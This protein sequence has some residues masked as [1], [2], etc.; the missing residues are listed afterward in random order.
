MGGPD[1]L[2]DRERHVLQA[3]VD[4]HI[5]T[6]EPVGSRALAS[7]RDLGVSSATIRSVMGL[8]GERGLIHQPHTSAGRIPTDRG[9][10][11]YVDTLLRL[12][13]PSEEERK[14]IMSRIDGAGAIDLAIVEA[15]RVLSKLTHQACV[16]VAP[17]PNGVR[18][19][20][21]EFV[22][23]R[24]DAILVILV[25]VEGLV[26]NRLVEWRGAPDKAP[27]AA[28][29]DRMGNYLTTMMAGCTFEEGRDRLAREVES[30]RD[31]LSL[32]E[33]SALEVGRV[34][35]DI[36]PRSAAS[37]P[38]VHVEGKAHLLEASD[39]AGLDKMREIFHVLEER[40][41]V[42]ELFD[43]ASSA[44]GIRIFIGGE[45]QSREFS[46]LTVVT[47]PYGQKDGVLGTLGVIGPTRLDYARVVPLVD[48]TAQL[49]SRILS[50]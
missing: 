48:L 9:Y 35:L 6:A 13:L 19:K 22:R 32:L 8:L 23:L 12:Q 29:L 28:E 21:V 25:S 4:A 36:R 11:Y 24:D 50:A 42:K 2:T 45:N 34:A 33:A 31:D 43:R 18:L 27:P 38:S 46:D 3:L 39:P 7:I 49:V 30:A 10:R 5:A 41:R 47:A 40:T 1:E 37:G 26:Q 44:A 16:V 15:S 17:A 20:Q 14:E